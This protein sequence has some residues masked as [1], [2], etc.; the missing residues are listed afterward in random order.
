MRISWDLTA[1]FLNWGH[2]TDYADISWFVM[3]CIQCILCILYISLLWQQWQLC[4]CLI[5]FDVLDLDQNK[6]LTFRGSALPSLLLPP[7]DNLSTWGKYLF[8]PRS[9]DRVGAFLWKALKNRL[10]PVMICQLWGRARHHG[11][12]MK[13]SWGQQKVAIVRPWAKTGLGKHGLNKNLYI[14][15]TKNSSIWSMAL[16]RILMFLNCVETLHCQRN[17]S[18]S[19]S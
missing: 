19:K 4:V 1:M 2:N 11:G 15:V 8:W 18:R 9:G 5:T 12:R 14:Y 6:L 10:A 13:G 17:P 7:H 3:Q 16:W